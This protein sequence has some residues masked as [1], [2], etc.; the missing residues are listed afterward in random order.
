MTVI[1]AAIQGVPEQ[2]QRRLRAVTNHFS[3]R[4][5]ARSKDRKIE[6]SVSTQSTGAC[7]ESLGERGLDLTSSG[8]DVDGEMGRV[9]NS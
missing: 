3:V 6:R 4:Q 7:L 5:K 1:D 9:T 8:E 2:A